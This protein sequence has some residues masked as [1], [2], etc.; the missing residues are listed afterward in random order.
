MTEQELRDE[1]NRQRRKLE[2]EIANLSHEHNIKLKNLK[3][4][5]DGE[6]KKLNNL[7]EQELQVC[8]C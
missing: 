1:A 2:E 8:R 5:Q 6:L 3:D 4:V 7:K